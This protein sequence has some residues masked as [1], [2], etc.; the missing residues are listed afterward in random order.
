M[1]LCH[2]LNGDATQKIDTRRRRGLVVADRV[3]TVTFSAGGLS[4]FDICCAVAV[5]TVRVTR[6]QWRRGA[7]EPSGARGDHDQD[8][9]RES[10]VCTSSWGTKTRDELALSK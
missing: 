8:R 7:R 1:Y 6:A 4:S 5:T 10:E 2:N 3:R 9:R